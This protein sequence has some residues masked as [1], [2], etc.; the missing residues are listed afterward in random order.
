[1]AEVTRT[2][3][4]SATAFLVVGGSWTAAMA[5]ANLA[6][7]LYAVYEKRFGFTVPALPHKCV[8]AGV[9]IGGDVISV[10]ICLARSYLMRITFSHEPHPAKIQ[11]ARSSLPH[12]DVTDK[13]P[14]SGYL[15]WSPP[16]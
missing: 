13:A 11:I 9:Q 7:P 14:T 2:R 3:T 6:T 1:M 15:T 12:T 16:V 5:A 4:R 10:N 8:S